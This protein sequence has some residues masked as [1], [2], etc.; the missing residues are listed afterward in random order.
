MDGIF[1][2]LTQT[3]WKTTRLQTRTKMP[4]LTLCD[5]W[6]TRRQKAQNAG[7]Y[8][9]L[10]GWC[11]HGEPRNWV[12]GHL[13]IP[14]KSIR[15]WIRR[16]TTNAAKFW[17]AV[18]HVG[19]QDKFEA[20][21]SPIVCIADVKRVSL[22]GKSS[23]PWDDSHEIYGRKMQWISLNLSD[24]AASRRA[25]INLSS[26]ADWKISVETNTSDGTPRSNRRWH[27]VD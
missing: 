18:I 10:A 3:F 5:V 25:L 1:N 2:T 21:A 16:W 24:Y 4:V 15:W 6:S 13:H 20:L 26:H 14:R 27:V 12:T 22:P 23:W 8:D 7:F 11:S 17:R 9:R 19:S